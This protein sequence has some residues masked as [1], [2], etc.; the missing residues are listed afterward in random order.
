MTAL[1]FALGRPL[2]EQFAFVERLVLDA[3][4]APDSS[5]GEQLF[6]IHGETDEVAERLASLG[7]DF[8][9]ATLSPDVHVG[10]RVAVFE[11]LEAADD[12]DQVDRLGSVV[13]VDL[14]AQT[15]DV[16][17]DSTADV[18]TH[19]L[20]LVVVLQDDDDDDEATEGSL[21]ASFTPLQAGEVVLV[22]KDSAMEMDDAETGKFLHYNDVPPNA[23]RARTCTVEFA[24]GG[25]NTLV[26]VDLVVRT[27][28]AIDMLDEDD[29][30]DEEAAPEAGDRVIIFPTTEFDESKAREGVLEE[31]VGNDSARVKFL[32]DD[33]QAVVSTD[34][35]IAASDG[36]LAS[37][38]AE[39]A[40]SAPAPMID[41]DEDVFAVGDK[42]LAFS[43]A[44]L[45]EA[46]MRVA[47]VLNVVQADGK[48][49][50][51]DGPA[52]Q[53]LL[54]QCEIEYADDKSIA[55]LPA[56]FL[57]K[58]EAD[59]DI[60]VEPTT[61][62]STAAATAED[63]EDDATT[64]ASDD[65]ES[66]NVGD[67]V[68]VFKDH[69]FDETT[70]RLASVVKWHDDATSRARRAQTTASGDS[71]GPNRLVDVRVTGDDESLLTVPAELL[72]AVADA[73]DP[74]QVQQINNSVVGGSADNNN[75][76]DDVATE[77]EAVEGTL[78][79]V[80]DD[81]AHM[82]DEDPR[83]EG[84]I[85]RLL[86]DGERVEVNFDLGDKEQPYIETVEL[87]R[88]VPLEEEEDDDDHDYDDDSANLTEDG[89]VID[90]G[91]NVNIFAAD[92][93]DQ[94][95]LSRMRDGVVTRLL[96]ADGVD[97]SDAEAD[98]ERA[99]VQYDD[100]NTLEVVDIAQLALPDAQVKVGSQV[101]VFA[102]D[103]VEQVDET[104]MREAI[105]VNIVSEEQL[106]VQ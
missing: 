91:S 69:T 101:A 4:C 58:P 24:N 59:D 40:A 36:D 16:Q 106:E 23:S 92:D 50:A 90:V 71:V 22:F 78:V 53:E 55:V 89:D 26:S 72:M 8:D 31:Y 105:V 39:Q 84:H 57:L 12:D 103:D 49:A 51:D 15:A 61:V 20:D 80:F 87:T 33:S 68:F 77:V 73:V 5:V 96:L 104:R 9:D 97:E 93:P 35:F 79:A 27:D 76:D 98:F 67:A 63:S 34:L 18:E 65:E 28:E 88:C 25:V 70:M 32:D 13:A 85:H 17:M 19:S 82:E 30:D 47:T 2:H 100:D 10:S 83:R 60:V 54:Q 46:T 74:S 43:D 7:F 41:A 94:R 14:T 95:D 6:V 44:S 52:P 21:A 56:A 86:E 99:E 1:Q 81:V 64:Q 75:A 38:E 42:V 62:D 37:E 3:G 29:M 66:F 11:S 48:M 45:D 102:E